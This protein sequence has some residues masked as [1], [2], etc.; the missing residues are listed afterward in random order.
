MGFEFVGISSTR[1][2]IAGRLLLL[3][4][5]QGFIPPE[6]TFDPFFASFFGQGQN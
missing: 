3:N 4:P 6:N 1:P 5:F 2:A